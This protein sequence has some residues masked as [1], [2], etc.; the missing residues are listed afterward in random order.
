MEK[1][2]NDQ[3]KNKIILVGVV[4]PSLHDNQPTPVSRGQ[5]MSGVEIQANIVNMLLLDYRLAP[6]S[7]LLAYIWLVLAAF[8]P[9]LIL[10]YSRS[11]PTLFLSNFGTGF[12]YLIFQIELFRQGVAANIIHIHLA[13]VSCRNLGS[14]IARTIA[15]WSSQITNTFA[16]FG[17]IM[18]ISVTY[19]R[20]QSTLSSRSL[21]TC[22][23]K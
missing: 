22:G 5:V 8:A 14:G 23:L 4:A 15:K 3:L 17:T 7:P 2:I 16:A 11:L 21:M 12:L 20:C 6:L 19:V 9:L 10:F 13:Y 18:T 1:D